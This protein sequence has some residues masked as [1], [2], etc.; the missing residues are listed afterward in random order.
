MTLGEGV[1]DEARHVTSSLKRIR[2]QLE[3]DVLQIGAVS[4]T[5]HH[6]GDIIKETYD[7]HAYN[8]KGALYSTKK[9]LISVKTAAAVEKYSVVG[10]LF[11]FTTVVVYIIVKRTRVLIWL[12]M[13]IASVMHRGIRSN[14]SY[15]LHQHSVISTPSVPSQI[16]DNDKQ[17]TVISTSHDPSRR[18]GDDANDGGNGIQAIEED[19]NE[20]VVS[21]R[22]GLELMSY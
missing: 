11:F 1:V 7:E 8:L 3:V 22:S 15:S 18:G 14:E 20:C 13:L 5:L 19:A 12:W 6:D 9:R 16:E 10:T 2:K 4:M 17:H 21:E